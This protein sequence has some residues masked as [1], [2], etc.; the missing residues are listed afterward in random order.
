MLLLCHSLNVCDYYLIVMSDFSFATFTK[1]TNRAMFLS[2]FG[3]CCISIWRIPDPTTR[4]LNYRHCRMTDSPRRSKSSTAFP[5]GY[6]PCLQIESNRQLESMFAALCQLK[7][8]EWLYWRLGTEKVESKPFYCWY[9]TRTNVVISFNKA[10]HLFAVCPAHSLFL[11][12][13]AK[14]NY[15]FW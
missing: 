5:P 15:D 12:C 8:F 7:S 9:F 6:W 4:F 11:L 13:D 2:A 14:L 1:H 3:M 10:P